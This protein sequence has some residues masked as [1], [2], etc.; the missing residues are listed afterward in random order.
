L[1]GFRLGRPLGP[2]KYILNFLIY[3]LEFWKIQEKKIIDYILFL[4]IYLKNN[5]FLSIT[6]K[7]E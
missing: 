6:K 7:L 3:H 2:P 5:R 4:K 1:A